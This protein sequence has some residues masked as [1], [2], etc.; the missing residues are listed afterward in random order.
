LILNGSSTCWRGTYR[1]FGVAM[2]KVLLLKV[3]GYESI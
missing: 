1:R 3:A 2:A